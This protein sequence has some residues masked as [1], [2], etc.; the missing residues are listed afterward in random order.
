MAIRLVPR[1]VLACF[2]LLPMVLGAQAR[3]QNL[4][5][6]KPGQKVTI[7]D[8]QQ[9]SQTG[10]FVSYSET[11]LIVR[12]KDGEKKI[13]RDDVYRITIPNAHRAPHALIGLLVGAGVG[14]GLMGAAA[15]V[16]DVSGGDVAGVVAGSAGIGAGI[17]AL[18]GPSKTIYKTDRRKQAGSRPAS[19]TAQTAPAE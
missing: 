19:A 14:A 1:L 15:H 5:Q 2:F 18:I 17:G 6:L 16:T 13:E 11:G 10:E 4:E 9:K 8:H 7:Q 3:W 12:S